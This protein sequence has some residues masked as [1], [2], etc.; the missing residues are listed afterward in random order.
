MNA[1]RFSLRMLFAAMAY[2]AIILVAIGTGSLGWANVVY[3]ITIGLLIV[4]TLMVVFSPA[5]PRTFWRGF[6]LIAWIY[7]FLALAPDRR[8]G[9]PYYSETSASQDGLLTQKILNVAYEQALAPMYANRGEI[10][11][12]NSGYDIFKYT[13]WHAVAQTGHCVW[14][15]VLGAI[16][17]CLAVFFKNRNKS[18]ADVK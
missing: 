16:G 12:L 11:P 18:Q 6:C 1:P 15:F 10:F 14:T 7:L 3:N 5:S 13:Q 2:L 8:F 17:G 9:D 4:A